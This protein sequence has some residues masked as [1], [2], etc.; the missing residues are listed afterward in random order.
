MCVLYRPPPPAQADQPVRRIMD[1]SSAAK[2]DEFLEKLRSCARGETPFSL[3]LRDPSG[4]SYIENPRAPL[5]DPQLQ[6]AFFK[7]SF[8]EVR[9]GAGRGGTS[10]WSP[11]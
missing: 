2:I 9:S 7:R 6:V 10:G 11:R 4:N 1:E 5:A 8:D 3:L